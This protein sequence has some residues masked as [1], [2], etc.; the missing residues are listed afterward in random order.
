MAGDPLAKVIGKLLTERQ[1]TLAVCESCTGGMLGSVITSIPGSTEYFV[2]GIVAY[3]DFTKKK[4]VG[5]KAST[6]NRSGAVSANVA[7]EMALGVKRKLM[8]DI[9]IGITGIAGP[10]GGSREKPLGL[11]YIGLAMK[12]KVIVRRFLF[13]GGRQTV[14]RSACKEALGLLKKILRDV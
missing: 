6:L 5:V 11:V 12:G 3:S 10:T 7:K 4:I 8:S 2:G 13:K 14:R 1:M 9:G